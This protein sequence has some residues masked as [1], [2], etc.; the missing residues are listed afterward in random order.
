[1]DRERGP[2]A[3]DDNNVGII[4]EYNPLHNG[5]KYH[6][7]RARELSGAD[8]VVVVLSSNFTQRG[9]PALLS[10]WD[11]AECALPA[12]ADLVLGLP[13]FFSCHSAGAFA[14]GGVD[15]LAATGIVR[16]ISFG[17][18]DPGFDISQL[19]DILVQ[20]P[21]TFKDSL[22]KHL[23]SGFSYVKARVLALSEADP[24]Y[25]E[26]I[27]R[28]NNSLAVAYMERIRRSPCDI[29][30]IPVQRVG[31]GYHDSALPAPEGGV[32]LAGASAIR[33]SLVKN[34]LESVLASMPR[35][36][37]DILARR[38]REGRC[39]TSSEILFRIAKALL[40]RTP[41]KSLSAY[42]GMSEGVG[43]RLSRL[44]ADCGSWEEFVGK[45]VTGRYTRGRIQRLV[46]H[47]LLGIGQEE[48][49]RLQESGPAYIQPL[50]A[51]DRGVEMLRTMRKRA[52]LPLRG[53][54]LLHGRGAERDL[55]SIEN[56]ASGLWECVADSFLPGSE[57]RRR[58]FTGRGCAAE[59]SAP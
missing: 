8:G 17:M 20:E 2:A 19:L 25:G 50:A 4:A 16:S 41:R 52:S 53:K 27:S 51:N 35:S 42:S 33:R 45:C 40:L 7:A 58:F 34:G 5:H 30:C 54:P 38:L 26:F 1:M 48:N 13:A 39:A 47:L 24:N 28:P 59:G 57:K 11:R 10:R 55:A 44:A 37:V 15:T 6:I 14:A 36:T 12:G 29:K 56:R 23:N 18:E 22:K 21:I 49:V 9:E 31:G 3:I 32:V 43:N 46:I